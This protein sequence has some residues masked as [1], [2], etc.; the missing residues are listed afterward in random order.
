MSRVLSKSRSRPQDARG[1]F[2]AKVTIPAPVNWAFDK[3]MRVEEALLR[4]G[5]RLPFGGSL[6]IVGIRQ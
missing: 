5:L 6:L 4:A 3:V 2:A 1:E